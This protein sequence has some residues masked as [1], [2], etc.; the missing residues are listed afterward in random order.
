MSDAAPHGTAPALAAPGAV[1]GLATR[2]PHVSLRH[3][4]R[5]KWLS[6]RSR[7]R[8]A[9][10]RGSRLLLLG[11]VGLVFWGVVMTVLIRLLSYFRGIPE[12]GSLLAAKLLGLAML[13]FLALLL[14]SN[15]ITALSTFFLA[16]DLDMVAAAPVDWLRLYGARLIETVVH[17]SWMV[18]LMAIP[19]LIAY[20][21]AYGAGMSFVPLAAGVLVPFLV[22]PAAVGAAVTLLLVNVF[23]ARR[24]RDILSFLAVLAAAALALLFRLL[25][26]EQLARPEGFRSLV[27]FVALLRAPA[28]PLLPSDWAQRAIMSWLDGSGAPDLLSL[29]LLWTTAA[30]A[31]VAGAVLHGRFYRRA[32]SKAQE[33][34]TRRGHAWSAGASALRALTR[35]LGVLRRELV[36]KEIRLFFRDSTQW[37][38]LVLLVVLLLVYVANIKFLPL[39]T[40]GVSFFLLNMIPFLNLV[41]AGFVLAS[42]AARFIFPGVSV[43]GRTLWLLRSSP[44]P[45][46]SLLWAK[47]WTGT[48]PLLLLALAIVVVTNILMDVSRFMMIVSTLTIVSMTFALSAMALGIGAMYPQFATENVAQIPTSFGGLVYMMAAV[49]LI[50]GVVVS[51]ARPVYAYLGAHS[52]GAHAEPWRMVPGFAIAA[53]LCAAATVLPLRAAV[54][55]LEDVE[56]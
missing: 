44:M 8:V 20:G 12:I 52:F 43:E 41:L 5:P 2:V 26:P 25:R 50:G 30:V 17:S 15:V 9:R 7:G 14:L 47:Y 29:Y 24:T 27:D 40:E 36:A 10:T 1:E 49:A 55:R 38:Q 46:R 48:V 39:H 19:I 45:V 3:L 16:R 51:E 34:A 4:L 56:P 32:F 6:A 35:P 54:R 33:G 42:I 22:I 23:P 53:L 13:S 11:T 18:V 31:V 37:S 28:S 21:H